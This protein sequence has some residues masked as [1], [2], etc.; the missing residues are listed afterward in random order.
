MP[1]KRQRSLLSVPGS[2]KQ[3]R[4]RLPVVTINP[5]VRKLA[6][7]TAVNE[8][9]ESV[10]NA[11]PLRLRSPTAGFGFPLAS[12]CIRTDDELA[13]LAKKNQ[14]NTLRLLPNHTRKTKSTK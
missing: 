9:D 13:K 11:M 4:S 6:F 12:G 1:S 8:P 7:P 3:K 5:V 14:A 10:S 2:N